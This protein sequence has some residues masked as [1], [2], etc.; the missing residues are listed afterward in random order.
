L[1]RIIAKTVNFSEHIA[2]YRGLDGCA[3]FRGELFDE[4]ESV[5]DLGT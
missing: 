3:K 1:S 4:Q 5:G 2:S